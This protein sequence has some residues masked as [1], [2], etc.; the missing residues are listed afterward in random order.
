MCIR[1]RSRM[2]MRQF[3][4]WLILTLFA[5][6]LNAQS[7]IR[8]PTVQDCLGAIP[9]C[10]P[11]YTTTNSYTGHGNVYP[12]I[13]NTGV[14]PLCMD[15]E[16]NDV[17]YIITVQTSGVLRFSLTP[18]NPNNDYDWSLFNMTNASCDEI[19]TS[20]TSLQVSCNSWGATGFNGPTGINTALGNSLNCNGPGN[21]PN[22]KPYNKDLNVLAGQ[23]YVLNIS[24][25]SATNQSGYTLDFSASTAV[26]FDN[27]APEIDSIQQTVSCA[28]ESQLYFRFT[29]NVKCID[30]F[31]HPEKFNLTGPAG[32]Y[33]INNVTSSD[34]STGATQSP[35]YYLVVS[36][37]LTAGNYNLSIIGDIHDLCDNVAL[38]ETYPFQLT[39]INAPQASAGND[40]TISNGAIINLHGSASGGSGGYTYHWEPANLLVNPDIP[41]PT[42]INMGASSLFTL[43]I[44][45]NANC[46]GMDEV[47][48]TVVGGALGITAMANPSTICFG[49]PVVLSTIASGGSGNYTYSWSSNPPGFSS[50]LPGPTVYPTVSTTYTVQVND[51]F[52]TKSTSTSVTVNPKPIANAGSSSS[53]PYGTNVTLQGSAIGGSGNYH[54]YWTS[55][56]PG[57]SSSEPTPTVVNLTQ[58]TIFNL[59]VTDQNTNCA[60]EVAEVTVTVTGSPLTCSPVATH[61]I[62]CYGTSTQLHAMAGGGSGNYTYSWTSIPSGF[63]SS[64]Q[65]PMV[66]PG[67]PTTYAL[68]VSDGYNS[69]SG[70]VSVLVNPR[71]AIYLGPPDT[72]VCVFE[73]VILDAGNPGSTY[74]WSN[75]AITPS[76][77]VSTTG[78][79]YDYQTYQVKVINQYACIDSSKI[80]VIFSYASCTGIDDSFGKSRVRIYP[81]PTPGLLMVKIDRPVA[82]FEI[83]ISNLLGAAVYRSTHFSNGA[84]PLI[85]RL[86]LSAQPSGF[87]MIT[88]RNKDLLRTLKFI[89]E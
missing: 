2:I 11:V 40:T 75:G 19:Y 46:H 18:N 47:L 3:Y 81:N 68:T 62:L 74:Y 28:G 88:F 69:T 38:Y 86:D 29:E 64:E 13:H 58:T 56:P 60:S 82:A 87:Y 41:T 25:W 34:C 52:S 51:G 78:I 50:T 67:V 89:K 10:Q 49:A 53:I 43:T 77:Q 23:T 17:F 72:N 1:L 24:N 83:G 32:T 6:G 39:E 45:D 22:F 15:G 7:K 30:A 12:E 61:P 79:G 27:V 42:T 16:K 8:I 63:N 33:T 80:N 35:F 54:F 9:V 36:P 21:P 20:A 70:N 65:N 71:P 66:M 14:C 84:D 44:T 26:I 73:T 48:V 31:Q 76:I 4:L 85:L 5:P 59:I 55:N 37:V 57:F